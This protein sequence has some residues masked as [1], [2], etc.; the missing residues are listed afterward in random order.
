MAPRRTALGRATR[1]ATCGFACSRCTGVALL[2]AI[3]PRSRHDSRH[4]QSPFV[5]GSPV[6]VA[7]QHVREELQPPSM[8]NTAVPESVDHVVLHALGKNHATRYQPA[9][10]GLGHTRCVFAAAACR[11]DAEGRLGFACQPPWGEPALR[12]R[13]SRDRQD[14][15]RQLLHVGS[16][17]HDEA[18]VRDRIDVEDWQPSPGSTIERVG[19][20]DAPVLVLVR[21][22]QSPPGADL[23]GVAGEPLL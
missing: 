16:C 9:A 13:L 15:R 20:S 4:G 23:E 18:A 11:M 21:W 8:Y 10:D 14:G 2:A 5:A 17:C 1:P 22:P 19:T 3:D 6:A 12:P 7:Y